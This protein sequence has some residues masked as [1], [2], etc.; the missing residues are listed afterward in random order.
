D[1]PFQLIVTTNYDQLLERALRDSGRDPWVIVQPI[2]GFKSTDRR[3]LDEKL[4][5]F[6]GDVVY[7]IHGSFSAAP[8]SPASSPAHWIV[9][10]EEDYIKFL[11]TITRVKEGIPEQI[12][13]KLKLSSLLFLGYSLEDWDFRTLYKGMIETLKERDRWTSFAIQ[14]NPT[15]FWVD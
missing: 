9:I 4:A 10:T 2:E 1:P 11:L 15:P 14:R 12:V 3:K 8:G 6:E 7:K 5:E 13:T